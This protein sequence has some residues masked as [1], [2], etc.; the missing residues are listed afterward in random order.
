MSK[1][2]RI[3]AKFAGLGFIVAV[4]LM[5]YSLSSFRTEMNQTIFFSLCPPAILLTL[6]IDIEPTIKELVAVC[7][8]IA[9]LNAALYAVVA[10]SLSTLWTLWKPN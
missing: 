6:Y 5:A 9:S 7:L 8:V 1:T 10:A 3:A 2:L 4:G